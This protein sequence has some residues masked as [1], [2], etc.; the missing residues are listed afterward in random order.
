MKNLFPLMEV[1]K[2]KELKT[3]KELF[4]KGIEEPDVKKTKLDEDQDFNLADIT[5][6]SV[7]QVGSV[8][9]ARDFCS[10][11]RQKSLS[12]GE[13]CQQLTGRIE[14]LLGNKNTHYYMKCISCIQSFREQSIQICNAEYYNSYMRSLK[15]SI[16]VRGLQELWDLL[17]QDLLT[18]ISKDEVDGSTVSK[19]DA[20]EFL[21]AEKEAV[22]TAPVMEDPGDVDDLF[23]MM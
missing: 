18:L 13:V 19:Q 9:P 11:I 23:D 14:Q 20:T 22:S 12:F 3:S 8:D 7:T 6:G 2:K 21:S 5:E 17:V 16:P 15:R 4:G 1:V 10:L